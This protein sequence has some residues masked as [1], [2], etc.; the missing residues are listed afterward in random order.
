MSE[1][2]SPEG[3][4]PAS[5]LQ[6]GLPMVAKWD[7]E[8]L[9][10]E[11]AMLAELAAKPFLAR[12]R[13]YLGKSGPGWLQS[14]LTL[15][16]GSATSSLFAGALLG[17]SLLWVQPLGMVLGVLMFAV[18]SHQTLSTGMRPFE[19]M[20]RFVHPSVAWAWAFASLLA[21][22]IWHVPQYSVGS[23]V[24]ADMASAA[25]GAEDLPRWPFGAA[26]LAI[27]ICVTWLYGSS[28]RGIRRYEF[29]LKLMVWVII[30]AFV[31]VIA[32]TGI[33]WGELW[34][35]LFTFPV[36]TDPQGIA[37]MVGGLSACVGINMTFLYPYTL[38]ARGWGRE[39]RGLAK[40]DLATGMFL[41]FV[42]ATGLLVIAAANT[43]Q[44]T[45]YPL[46]RMDVKPVVAAGTLE[47]F[48]GKTLGRVMFDL[49]ILSMTL[50]SI[51]LHMVVA[52]FIV[53]EALKVEPTGWRYRLASLIPVPGFFGAVFWGEV[54]LWLGVATSAICAIL[55][56]IAYVGFAV[57][58]NRGRYLGADKPRGLRACLWNLA[59]AA[60]IIVVAWNA[61]LFVRS[62]FV[63]VNP[64]FATPKAAVETL[65]QAARKD[66][67][68]AV[69]GAFVC[70]SD[71][72]RTSIR[73]L[74]RRREKDPAAGVDYI[75][76][77][78]GRLRA[79]RDIQVGEPK[80]DGGKAT[81]EL[82]LDGAAA[83]IA[84][85]Q[86]GR[87]HWKVAKVDAALPDLDA[88]MKKPQAAPR[89]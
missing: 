38:L 46:T 8:A 82:K 63:D 85:V 55:L 78:L 1:Q 77:L 61:Y 60:A 36:P 19:A 57:L 28:S 4:S 71:A 31:L 21:T 15:G 26:M 45:L 89:P 29:A 7:P 24:F 68:G 18:I 33:R 86:Q 17:Y 75:G 44:D 72:T 32:K 9:A 87:S 12:M 23:S 59:M 2:K 54:P 65:L 74:A 76:E 25:T 52:A 39:H 5:E 20:S 48:A 14:A 53:C 37:V 50:S 11:K 6:R 67:P 41:P 80:T 22:L 88:W 42:V 56:P 73:T 70:F 30:V 47:V 64:K 13:G 79:A 16:A 62:T 49:G 84:L 51:T 58:H 27:C 69:T 81:V 43:L 10:R 34:R 83:I 40:F 66:G 3:V 35:G